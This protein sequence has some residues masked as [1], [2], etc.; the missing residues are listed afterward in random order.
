MNEFDILKSIAENFSQRK[1][2][3]ALNNYEVL[4]NNIKFLN[5][6]Y[7]EAVNELRV[8]YDSIS[9]A[10]ENNDFV[11]DELKDDSK[12][13]FYF[14]KII[15]R[16]ILNDL[17]IIEK[18]LIYTTPD[19]REGVDIEN[20]IQLRK[21]FID[22]NNLVTS[23]RQYIDSLVSESYQLLKLEP[24]E[25]NFHVLKSLDS[26]N[27]YATK[28]IRKSLFNTEIEASLNEYKNL[29]NNRKIRG[30]ESDITK[31]AEISFGKKVE[32]LFTQL[33]LLSESEFK[34]EIKNLFSFSSEFTHIGYISTFFTSST[35]SEVVFKD[36]IGPYLPSTENF[37]ELKYEILETAIKFFII[38]YIPSIDFAIKKSFESDTYNRFSETLNHIKSN[39]EQN[40]KTRNNQYY[41]FIRQDLIG[42]D[43]VIDLTCIC[44]TTRN[45]EPPH[46]KSDIYCS[47]CGSKFNL[48]EVQGDPG[49]IITSKGPIKVIGSEVPDFNDLPIDQQRELLQQCENLINEQNDK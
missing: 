16:I 36:D 2:T 38:I 29:S 45:W 9:E 17:S 39:L 11:T 15:P 33:N 10:F 19:N 31:C 48:I 21:T 37:S 1:S 8:L 47:N 7:S 40:L 35:N 34:E 3:A 44:G 27:K 6:S 24:K 32:Y 30:N 14:R 22:F 26:F 25:I 28:S 49:Y 41:F 5:D 43:N 4:G 42:S 18:F 46:D 13:L 20:V 23:A 12:S